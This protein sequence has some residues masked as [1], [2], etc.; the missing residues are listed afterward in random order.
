M[1]AL[2]LA[3]RELRGCAAGLRLVLACLALGVAAIAAIGSLRAAVD[4][5]LAANG[6]RILDGDIAIVG[7]AEPL[8]AALSGWLT[9]QG[10]RVSAIVQMRSLLVAPSGERQLVELKAVDPAWP[11]VGAARL[12]P[13]RP[14]QAALAE[15]GEKF[16]LVAEPVVLERLG[17]KPGDAARLGNATFAVRGVLADEP[18]RVATTTLFGPRVLIAAAALPATGLVQPGSI[19]YYELRAALPPRLDPAVAERRL[20]AAFPG[21]HW[22]IRDARHAVPGIERFVSQTSLFLSLVGLTALLVSGVGIANGVRAWLDARAP[23][24]ATLRCLGAS[25]PL[26]FQVCLIEIGA[27]LLAGI[28]AGLVAGAVVPIA[29]LRLF[30]DALPVPPRLGLY[31]APLALAAGYGVLVAGC[32][33]LWPLGRAMRIPGAMLFRP[34]TLSAARWPGRLVAPATAL[35]AALLVALTVL[36]AP[37][38]GFAL[39]FAGA[40]ATTLLLLRL[41]AFALTWLASRAP[42]LRAPW[43]RLGLANLHRPGTPA[44]LLLVSIGVGLSTLAAVGLIEANIRHQ[45]ARQLP[46]RAPSFYF[47]DIQPDQVARF[48]AMLRGFPGANEIRTV[49]SLRAR[50]VAVNGV[51]ADQVHATPE[52]AWALRGDRGLTYVAQPPEGSRIIAGHWWPADYDG[53]PLLSLD[54]ELARGWGVRLGD[55]ITLNVLGR[56]LTLQVASLRD[57]DWKSLSLNFALVASPGMLAHAPHSEIATVR[58]EPAQQGAVLRAVTDALPNVT[59]ILVADVLHTIGRLLGQVAAALGAAG[60]VT[61]VSGT[62]VLAGA[63]AAAQRQRVREAVILKALGATRRQLLAAWLVE[64][65]VLGA[66]AGLIAAAIGTAVSAGVMRGILESDWAFMPGV[67]AAVVAGAAALTLLLGYAAIAAPLRANV[68]P[69]LRND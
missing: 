2:R 38:R 28:A 68:A 13:P 42:R 4:A 29:G 61:L 51:P 53:P 21:Q 47:I 56:D 37:D 17:L 20:R 18:D 24:V 40:A 57:I 1:L 8:P 33:S 7:G 48:T 54:A 49:P 55:T 31:P 3:V 46:A 43:A 10:A 63:V 65:G 12:V 5:G 23:T 39:R 22:R 30:G 36:T 26:V 59:G 15:Q 32:F 27:L 62:L 11:L 19:L 67:L 16:G 66:A 35:L 45:I 60:G 50:V 25:G 44:P 41:G 58:V 14:V 64:F 6:R 69:L 9:G 34:A 52:T